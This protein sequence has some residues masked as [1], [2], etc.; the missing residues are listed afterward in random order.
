MRRKSAQTITT[1]TGEYVQ[2]H[3]RL[4]KPQYEG[5]W[6]MADENNVDITSLILQ[7]VDV[8]LGKYEASKKNIVRD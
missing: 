3:F 1:R 2:F 7:A 5:L 6:D 8:M 4:T